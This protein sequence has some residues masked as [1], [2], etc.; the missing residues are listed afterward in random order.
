MKSNNTPE[1]PKMIS[2]KPNGA[3][4]AL[5]T[6]LDRNIPDAEFLRLLKGLLKDCQGGPFLYEVL[7][8]GRG[9]SARLE[10]WVNWLKGSAYNTFRSEL[11]P[12]A[13]LEQYKKELDL[14]LK[15]AMGLARLKELDQELFQR[16]FDEE[17]AAYLFVMIARQIGGIIR[18]MGQIPEIC[19]AMSG[20]LHI[21]DLSEPFD[22]SK[23]IRRIRSVFYSLG[24][25]YIAP[26]MVWS[27]LVRTELQKN[28]S[29]QTRHCYWRYYDLFKDVFS[30]GLFLEITDD[31]VDLCKESSTEHLCSGLAIL[32]GIMNIEY[33]NEVIGPFGR[34]G[35]KESG[36]IFSQYDDGFLIL[37]DGIRWQSER[38]FQQRRYEMEKAIIDKNDRELLIMCLEKNVIPTCDIKRLFDLV[39]NDNKEL[40]P[41][42]ILKNHGYLEHGGGE[43]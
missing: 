7:F 20:V 3:G 5:I 8:S 11:D 17:A 27:M 4:V 9:L 43:S 1:E 25:S 15:A 30:T 12:K 13:K 29:L 19:K 22:G 18:V 35:M 38:T 21:R 23:I 33:I 26:E 32:E 16:I 2:D 36:Y 10:F 31:D 34:R 40:L 41:L 37:V 28:E 24:V 14:L 42:L 39:Q 6:L